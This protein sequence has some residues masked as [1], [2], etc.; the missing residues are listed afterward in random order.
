M[1]RSLPKRRRGRDWGDA[2]V[3]PDVR[4]TLEEI[5]GTPALLTTLKEGWPSLHIRLT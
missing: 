2:R 4:N 1:F 5:G 3:R